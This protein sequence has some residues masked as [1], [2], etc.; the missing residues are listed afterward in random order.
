MAIDNVVDVIPVG[1][2]FMPAAGAMDVVFVV[3][4]ATVSGRTGVWILVGH[5][6]SM[7]VYVVPVH[8]MQVTVVKVVNVI[9]VSNRRMSAIRSMNV[10]V[11]GVLVAGF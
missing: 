9:A 1:H 4:G 2:R 3:S 10:R 8:V 7:F 6:E 11:V 5:V